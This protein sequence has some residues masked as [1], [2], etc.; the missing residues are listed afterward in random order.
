MF[1]WAWEMGRV[2]LQSFVGMIRWKSYMVENIH[3]VYLHMY[4]CVHIHISHPIH[5]PN[6][7]SEDI[8]LKGWAI[9]LK[10][11]R[12]STSANVTWK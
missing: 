3:L 6:L 10:G 8:M 2:S 1:C 4:H 12:F 11:K 9:K 5:L 7:N